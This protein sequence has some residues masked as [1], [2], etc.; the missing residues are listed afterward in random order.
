MNQKETYC[1]LGENG[2]CK[3]YLVIVKFFEAKIIGISW[4]VIWWKV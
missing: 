1:F 3:V 4:N 2:W